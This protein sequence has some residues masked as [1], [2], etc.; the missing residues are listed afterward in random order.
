MK[1][2]FC[3][4]ILTHGRPDDV[5]T[6]KTLK[7]RGYT[8]KIYL[9]LDNEDKTIK[10]YIKNFGKENIL[11]FNKKEVAVYTDCGDNF[12]EMRAV[13]FA[14]NKLF[15]IAKKV[16]IKY[17]I[18]LDDDYNDFRYKT[19]DKLNYV[20]RFPITNLDKMFQLLLNYYKSI[21]ALSLS[22]AQGGDFFGGVMNDSSGTKRKCM[23]FYV[24]DSGKPFEFYG[25]INEDV[26]CYVLN[27]SRGGLF[28]TI[29]YIALQQKATQKTKGGLTD[30]YLS[31]GTYIKSFYTV[32][33]CP[34]SC[35]VKMMQSKHPRLHH[36]ISWDNAVPVII[37]EKWKKK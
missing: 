7:R 3:V 24:C 10:Q 29:P 32:I 36:S 23:N 30:I 33:F 11:V 9:V 25:R 4:F 12:N 18:S 17:F 21:S 16:G 15:D 14:R 28:L 1:N 35:K 13:I 34:S 6:Y 2:N 8:G 27:G 20:D 22:I 5:I 26:T 37:N 19:D 31:Y